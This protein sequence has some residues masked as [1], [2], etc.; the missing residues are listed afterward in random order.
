MPPEDPDNAE[1]TPDRVF[2]SATLFELAL[3][4]LAL[5]L[6]WAIGPSARATVP[7]LVIDEVW[8]I[9]GNVLLGCVAAGPILLYV[10]IIRRIPWE[11]IRELERLT[12][13]GMLR[14]LLQL[15]PP[16]LIM[17]S[18]CAGIG[19]ELL[20][21]GWLMYWLADLVGLADFSGGADTTLAIGIALG[22]SS[23]I[24]GLFHPITKLYVVLAAL[25]GLYFGGLVLYTG[26]LLVP[27]AAHATYDAVQLI[28]TARNERLEASQAA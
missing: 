15:R 3:A 19:E 16:E 26:N 21:R 23:L 17:V 18:I 9:L 14:T 11:P 13:D 6:G 25:M 20:F 5:F 28:L 7:E 24:F 12:D 2:L 8:P 10:E 27:I 4:A 1:Q 22:L